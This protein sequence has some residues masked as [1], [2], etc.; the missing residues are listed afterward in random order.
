MD[1]LWG[2]IEFISFGALIVGLVF[3]FS[4]R[5]KDDPATRKKGKY[6]A[7]AGVISFYLSGI[8][9]SNISESQSQ[10][11]K[12]NDKKVTYEQLQKKISELK[13]DKKNLTSDVSQQKSDLSDLKTQHKDIINAVENKNKLEQQ[14]SDN[15]SKLADTKDKLTSL[16]SEISSAKDELSSLKG[17]IKTAET[18][19]KTLGAG[20]YTVGQDVPASRY[21][22][23]PI[24]EGSNFFVNEGAKVNTILGSNGEDSYVFYAEDGD[25]IRTEA[26]VKLIPVE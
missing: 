16:N 9:V 22:A 18:A 23:I 4:K 2:L 21:K 26:A 5:N 8:I 14:V 11:T 17:E 13:N 25:V 3:I 12:I 6:I 24:G 20:T 15:K 10:T 7:I 19:P 1:I